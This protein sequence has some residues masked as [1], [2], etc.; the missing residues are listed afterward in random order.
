M[1][2]EF[3]VDLNFKAL[4]AHVIAG[5]CQRA[6]IRSVVLCTCGNAA[7]ELRPHVP[8][9]IEIGPGPLAIFR[10]TRWLLPSDIRRMFPGKFD[11]TSGHLPFWM[12]VQVSKIVRDTLSLREAVAEGRPLV[13]PSGS[14][15]SAVVV[16]LAFPTANVVAQFDPSNP[17]TVWEPMGKRGMYAA[18][19]PMGIGVRMLPALEVHTVWPPPPKPLSFRPPA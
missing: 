2:F 4:R 16:K 17:A 10:P 3:L 19:E 9:V 18:F 7:A 11:A 14:G 5:Y 1:D 12:L 13:V 8:E 15:E 6:R